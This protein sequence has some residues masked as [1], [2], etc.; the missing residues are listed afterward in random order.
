[1]S[2]AQSRTGRIPWRL[3]VLAL[4]LGV[5]ASCEF[6]V[7]VPLEHALEVEVLGDATQPAS[8]DFGV[9]VAIEPRGG[10]QL[11]LLVV[12]GQLRVG[13]A[14]LQSDACLE[15]ADSNV[16]LHVFVVPEQSEA[17]LWAELYDS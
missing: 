2:F 3:N 11:R 5:L 8:E 7:P 13:G 9:R 1:M 12:G 6:E 17:L 16:P 10:D 14:E 15:L 4:A